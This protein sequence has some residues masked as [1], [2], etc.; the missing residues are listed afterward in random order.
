M[1]STA[2]RRGGFYWID[3]K[4]FVSVTQ[5]LQ[6]IDKPALRYWYGNQIYWEMVKDPNLDEKEAMSRPYQ[7]SKDAMARGTTVHTIVEAWGNIGDVRGLQSQ[8]AGY[9]RAFDEW[10]QTFN[11]KPLEHERTVISKKYG[12]A[13]TLDLLAEIGGE[14]YLIDVKTN[15]DAN[16]YDEV[17]LQLSAYEQALKEAGEKVHGLYGLALGENGE[18]NFKEFDSDL[19]TFLSVKRLWEWQNKG[20]CK[21]VGYKGGDTK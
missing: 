14:K 2:N 6:V 5:V 13:G 4:P 17:Q 21:K 18:F 3:G 20:K 19:L 15:A 1:S 12:F 11:P 10:R 16:L 8:F 9:A 7:T